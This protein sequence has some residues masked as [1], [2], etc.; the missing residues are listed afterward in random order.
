M[1]DFRERV[2]GGKPVSDPL[3]RAKKRQRTEP[4][5]AAEEESFADVAINREETRLA[6]HRDSDRHRLDNEAVKVIHEGCTQV[7]TLV[8]LSGGGAMIEGAK[9]LRLWDRVEL[10]FAEWASVEA[11]VRWIR[12]KRYGLEF[13]HETRIETGEEELAD[14]LRAVIARSFPDVALELAVDEP[15]DP[16][17]VPA[18]LRPPVDE[19]EVEQRDEIERDLRHPLIWSGLIHHDHESH[20]VRLRNISS[21]GAMIES[22]LP[23]KPGT[24]LL[25][26]LG[27]GGS[28]FATVHWARG[29]AAG[30]KFHAPY[31][32][33]QLAAARPEVASARWVA[34]DYLRDVPQ[35]NSP[36]AKQW[37]RS[38]LGSLHRQ[39]G[40]G[41]NRSR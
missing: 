8:N 37:G 38:D 40:S 19:Q 22:D 10:R 24:E 27:Q 3:L 26:D 16:A 15:E 11:A 32:L 4:S 25:L 2:L 1:N 13:A 31:D 12:G 7:V 30:L 28:I 5:R 29:D 20:V 33:R 23:L 17:S 39:L 14:M 35:G 36:W 18:Q 21:G 6:N 9:E 41:R 34:P